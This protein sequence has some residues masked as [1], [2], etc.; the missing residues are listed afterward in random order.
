MVMAW[1]GQIYISRS[2][3]KPDNAFCR[4]SYS[5][6][7]LAGNASL[8]ARG[9][10]SKGVLATESRRDGALVKSVIRSVY[11]DALFVDH[12]PSRKGSK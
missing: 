9:V 8:F 3:N 6:A 10:S 7:E 2:A 11:R 12:I 4:C 5:L 1:A